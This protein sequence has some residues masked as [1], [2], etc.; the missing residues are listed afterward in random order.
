MKHTNNIL[1]RH[2]YLYS[3]IFLVITGISISYFF[4]FG[5]AAPTTLSATP[6]EGNLSITAKFKGTPP[7]PAPL[8]I[9]KAKS[10]C[11]VENIPNETLIIGKGN[12]IK[13]TM[14][15]LKGAT[16]TVQPKDYTLQNKNCVF[17]PH[18][19]FVAAR[20][21]LVITNEDNI[22]HNV[23]GY[24]V[25]GKMKKTILN[26][27]LPSGSKP[28]TN[29]RAFAKTGLIEMSCDAHEWMSAKFIVVDNPYHAITGDNGK[30]EI[31]NIPAGEYELVAYHEKLGELTKKVKVTAGQTTDVIFEFQ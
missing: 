13:N 9:Q 26:V 19:G 3:L 6:A 17:S 28:I 24:W 5:Q 8:K 14:V 22:L 23:H 21:K 1:R 27:A 31:K 4:V 16:G 10:L 25:V 2:K 7:S 30:A 12:E 15:Y 18:V 20:S 29:D 11:G